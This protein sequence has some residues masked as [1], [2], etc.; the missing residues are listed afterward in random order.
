[1]VSPIPCSRPTAK[2]EGIAD[3]LS[4]QSLSHG[5]YFTQFYKQDPMPCLRWKRSVPPRALFGYPGKNPMRNWC[6][7]TEQRD[8]PSPGTPSRSVH[9]RFR[10][11]EHPA[12]GCQKPRLKETF[13]NELIWRDFYHIIL[14]HFRRWEKERRSNRNTIPSNGVRQRRVCVVVRGKDRLPNR[15]RGHAGAE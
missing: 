4:V 8:Y 5:N 1:M 15:R 9:L 7:N 10:H 2:M 14:W 11:G 12:T 6:A 13:I 3:A